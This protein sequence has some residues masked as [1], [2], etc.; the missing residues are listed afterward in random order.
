MRKQILV[1]GLSLMSF[2]TFAN[3]TDITVCLKQLNNANVQITSLQLELRN[4]QTT[5]RPGYG[6]VGGREDASIKEQLRA[7]RQHNFELTQTIRG[8]QDQYSDLQRQNSDLQRDNRELR[9]RIRDFERYGNNHGGGGY[10]NPRAQG[11][12]AV[13]GCLTS[14]G[15]VDLGRIAIGEAT[16]SLEAETK[17]LQNS[18]NARFCE[19]GSGIYKSE[20]ITTK[21]KEARYCSASCLD[22][23]GVVTNVKGATGRNLLEAQYNALTLTKNSSYCAS[24]VVKACE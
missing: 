11:Y 10:G 1:L 9:D 23:R 16:R 13:A 4:C 19:N 7:E 17:A 3:T 6:S 24:V 20:A 21:N 8:L 18:K 22:S 5:S 2:S 12:I 15:R 14:A